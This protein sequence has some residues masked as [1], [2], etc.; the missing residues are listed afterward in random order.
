MTRIERTVDLPSPPDEVFAVLTD[1]DR[2]HEWAT[3]VVET[4]D[5]SDSPMRPGCTFRQTVKVLGQEIESEWVV[6]QMDPPRVVSY[7]A[8]SPAGG[9]LRMTQRVEP[10]PPGGSRVHLEVDYELPGGLIGAVVDRVYLESHNEEEAERS[11]ANLR[12]LLERGRSSPSQ[13]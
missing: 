8:K 6:L 1:L 7:E 4:R 9:S 3:I 2:L 5:V 10:T 13:A 11:L 12:A